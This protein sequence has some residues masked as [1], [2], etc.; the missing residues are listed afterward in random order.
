MFSVPQASDVSASFYVNLPSVHPQAHALEWVEGQVYAFTRKRRVTLEMPY[1]EPGRN[2]V[3]QDG[4]D[5]AVAAGL[6]GKPSK[7]ELAGDNNDLANLFDLGVPAQPEQR[8]R[9]RVG[10]RGAVLSTD[11]QREVIFPTAVGKSGAVYEPQDGGGT[12]MNVGEWVLHAQ[13]ATYPKA[14]EPLVRL[15][16]ELDV[17]DTPKTVGTF[18]LENVALP[19]PPVAGRPRQ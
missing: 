6:D 10:Y 12:S 3:A 2:N 1:P 15:R 5:L 14:K 11:G 13:R 4:P 9:I 18:R 7:P 8:L 19:A 17:M 16:W